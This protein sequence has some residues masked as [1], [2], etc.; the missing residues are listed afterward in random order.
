MEPIRQGDIPGVQLRRRADVPRRMT[1]QI[2][3]YWLQAELQRLWLCERSR[4]EPGPPT[5][6]WLETGESSTQLL[7]EYVEVVE[8]VEPE[9]L[10]LGW[11]ELDAGW[12]AATKVTVEFE[13]TATGCGVMVFQE[14]FQKLPLS[15]GLT[16]WER[17]RR[18]WT[19]A[20]E[21]LVRLAGA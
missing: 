16:A 6:I 20:L 21:R 13:P 2:W 3:P 14:G 18:R 1:E 12:T 19:E 4:I 5:V 9:R 7:K 8:R 17:Y 10:V 15:I 11:R